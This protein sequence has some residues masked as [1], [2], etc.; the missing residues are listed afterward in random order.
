MTAGGQHGGEPG[1]RERRLTVA[2]IRPLGGHAEVMFFELARVCRLPVDAAGAQ[3][4]LALLRDAAASGEP[5]RVRFV[6]EHGD[7]IEAVTR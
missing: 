2:R 3:D 4:A 5:V 1:K 6:E 7:L